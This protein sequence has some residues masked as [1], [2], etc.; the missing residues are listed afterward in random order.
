MSQPGRPAAVLNLSCRPE[1]HSNHR[2][3]GPVLRQL[4]G[5]RGGT[6]RGV[7]TRG[8]IRLDGA[9]PPPEAYAC[10]LHKGGGWIAIQTRA[11]SVQIKTK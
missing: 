2:D 6:R 11:E 7:D 1:T 8:A 3:Q 5:S 4:G 9:D 10:K